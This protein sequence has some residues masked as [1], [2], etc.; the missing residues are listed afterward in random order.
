[1]AYHGHVQTLGL[2]GVTGISIDNLGWIEADISNFNLKQ[3]YALIIPGSAPNRL[4][5]R[6]PIKN[7][8]KLCNDL[9]AQNIQAVILGT[10]DEKNVTEKISNACTSVINLTGKTSLFDIAS[11][12]RS[13]TFAIGNDTGPMHMIAPTNCDTIV[14]FSKHSNPKRHAPLGEN[15]HTLQVKDL[16]DLKT[17]D[18]L[19]KISQIT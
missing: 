19:E 3:P 7:Y 5:K 16:A 6:W 11:L 14:L 15:V 9:A 4:E 18:V 2:A 13:A 8:I 12:A 17:A 1:M 10:E